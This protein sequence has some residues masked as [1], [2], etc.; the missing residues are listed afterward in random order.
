MTI[1]KNLEKIGE[2]LGFFQLE[3]YQSLNIF[4]RHYRNK[5]F[6]RLNVKKT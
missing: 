3:G 4:S 1:T 2:I 5:S 6:L